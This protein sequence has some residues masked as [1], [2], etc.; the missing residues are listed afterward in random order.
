MWVLGPDAPLAVYHV[1]AGYWVLG[2]GDL[3]VYHVGVG[4]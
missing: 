3:T 1:G 4:S 2:L